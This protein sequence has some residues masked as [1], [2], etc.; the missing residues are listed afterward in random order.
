MAEVEQTREC[1]MVGYEDGKPQK[2]DGC[3]DCGGPVFPSGGC[4]FCPSCGWSK[5]G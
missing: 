5:C 2:T 1:Q 4:V 3:P